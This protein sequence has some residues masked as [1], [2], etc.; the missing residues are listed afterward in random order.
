M[1]KADTTDMPSLFLD[2]EYRR[3][4][5]DITYDMGP[6]RYFDSEFYKTHVVQKQHEDITS[7]YFDNS[8]RKYERN[9]T[10]YLGPEA[11]FDSKF[12]K[13]FVLGIKQ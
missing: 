3:I 6:E 5:R 12:Y 1:R 8:Y 4:V 11:Y 7:P 9:N 13:R 10:Y 2:P